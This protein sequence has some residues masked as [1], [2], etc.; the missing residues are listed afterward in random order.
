MN[1]NEQNDLVKIVTN[2]YFDKPTGTKYSKEDNLELFR[3]ALIKLNGSEKFTRKDFEKARYN[4]VFD[5]I[6][7]TIQAITNEGIDSGH[8]IFQ[9]VE[10]KNLAD[11]DQNL[12][13]VEDSGLFVV[14]KIVDGTQQIRRQR[15]TGGE[16]V[17]VHTDE[18]GIKI[19]EEIRRI[20]TG[21]SD[22]VKF[23]QKVADSFNA[24]INEVM[25][26]AV[27]GAFDK[28]VPPHANETSAGVYDEETLYSIIDNVE[29]D[30]PGMKAVVLG[31]YQA[32][33]KIKVSG[34]DS[35][36]AKDDK[37][38]MGYYGRIGTTP[39]IGFKNPRPLGANE[40][41][42]FGNDL[43]VVAADDKFV[44]FVEEGETY[45][46]EGFP[47]GNKSLQREYLMT[48]RFGFEVIF[49][50]KVGVYKLA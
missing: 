16:E 2:T 13:V 31:S 15:L 42:K 37:Y 8:P 49:A 40:G 12:F 7:D 5:L 36:S 50:A 19:Y 44:K 22:I 45:I 20:F 6:T 46:A 33:R 32:V 39:I 48:Q 10:K 3:N 9:F 1:K 14:S 35:D 11:G 17:V 29:A 4:G 43:Y 27:I 38:N 26:D 41:F 34:S 28:I 18:Y 25:C 24:K 47:D 21:R 30:N 23:V